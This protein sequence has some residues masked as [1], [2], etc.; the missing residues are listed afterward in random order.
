LDG[1]AGHLSLWCW[2]GTQILVTA[3]ALALKGSWLTI[4]IFISTVET[5]VAEENSF[6]PG[7]AHAAS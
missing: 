7:G 1:H 4:L 6:P 2:A 5:G 3:L